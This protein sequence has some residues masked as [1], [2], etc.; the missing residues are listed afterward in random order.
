MNLD[1]NNYQINTDGYPLDQEDYSVRVSDCELEV[2]FR[3]Q[4][5]H[6]LELITDRHDSQV[7]QR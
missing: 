6:L 4:K 2:L 7:F 1:L 5:E 3:N